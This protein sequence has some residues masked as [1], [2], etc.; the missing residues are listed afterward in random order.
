L[1]NYGSANGFATL[2]QAELQGASKATGLMK[3]I[4][5][6]YNLKMAQIDS[7]F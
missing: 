2:K 7:K 5:L 4:K 1:T 6:A 3:P